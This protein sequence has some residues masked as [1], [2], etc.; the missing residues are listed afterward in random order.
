M[1]NSGKMEHYALIERILP[2]LDIED[3]RKVFQGSDPEELGRN[4]EETVLLSEVQ[5]SFLE[6]EVNWGPHSFQLRTFF[7][8]NS[9]DDLLFKNAAY[10]GEE[11]FCNGSPGLAQ[12][13]PRVRQVRSIVWRSLSNP[14]NLYTCGGFLS[15]GL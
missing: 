4:E 1:D 12:N 7:G 8:L 6:Q 5:C 10:S 9:V 2:I 15:R 14:T 3:I 13:V 11:Q